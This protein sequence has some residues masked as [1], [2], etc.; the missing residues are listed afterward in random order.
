VM[1]ILYRRGWCDIS[2]AFSYFPLP[3]SS[4]IEDCTVV[5]RIHGEN[6]GAVSLGP[7]TLQCRRYSRNDDPTRALSL[8]PA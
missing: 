6:S 1:K 7:A 8:S 2:I 5:S 3:P 4:T